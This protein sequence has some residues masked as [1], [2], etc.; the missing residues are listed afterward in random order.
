MVK[1]LENDEVVKKLSELDT[2]C[3]K[4]TESI[5]ILDQKVED[6][7]RLTTSVELI[8][9]DISYVKSDVSDVKESQNK[10]SEEI[11][12]VKSASSEKKARFLDDITSKIAWLAIGGFAIYILS[13]LL[14]QI[15]NN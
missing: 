11:K 15:Y 8:A 9:K 12:I 10:L 2:K 3:D 6:I 1:W 14:P 4:N 13:Q 7:H 5:K